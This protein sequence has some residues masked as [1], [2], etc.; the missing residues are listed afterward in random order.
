MPDISK[1]TEK[2]KT[3]LRLVAQG[4][5]TKH[6]ARQIDVSAHTVDQRIR[7]ALR[8]LEVEDRF[9]A[10][11]ILAEAE[12]D[13][14]YQRLIYQAK[15]LQ[16][17][18]NLDIVEEPATETAASKPPRI[19]PVGGSSNDLTTFEKVKRISAMAALMGGAI[20]SLVVAWLW[21]MPY[22]G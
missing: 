16:T 3:C 4:Y 20:L 9:A 18:T 7:N 2:Q 17:S 13:P 10:A 19:P 22:L 1:L 14:T 12:A 8:A 6:I 11:R 5:N 21:L 15:A